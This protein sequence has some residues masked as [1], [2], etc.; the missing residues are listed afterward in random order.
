MLDYAFTALELH[1]VVLTVDEFNTA[2]R[3]AYTK[4]GFVENGRL[5]GATLLAGKRYDRIV[6]DCTAEGFESPVLLKILQPGAA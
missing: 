4:A 3:R 1:T 5:R 2:A 6:M